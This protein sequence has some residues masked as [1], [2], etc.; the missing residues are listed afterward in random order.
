[1]LACYHDKPATLVAGSVDRIC[2]L[3]LALADSRL[4]PKSRNLRL[5]VQQL[6]N[7]LQSRH[8]RLGEAFLCC[9]TR[10]ILDNRILRCRPLVHTMFVP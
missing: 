6:Q 2:L 5:L 1:M 10:P 3:R 7:P 8:Q 4:A 9:R